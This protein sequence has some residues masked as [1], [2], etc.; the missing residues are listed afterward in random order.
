MNVTEVYRK[1]HRIFFLGEMLVWG[2]GW[3]VLAQQAGFYNEWF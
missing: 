3:G 2:T 1:K